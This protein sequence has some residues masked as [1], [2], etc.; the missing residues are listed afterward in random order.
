[1]RSF[2]CCARIAVSASNSSF[3]RSS[4]DSDH[5]SIS[6]AVS[7]V[8]VTGFTDASRTSLIFVSADALATST[9]SA[10]IRS[11]SAFVRTL[12]AAK[13]H[14]PS[15]IARTLKPSVS[16]RSTISSAPFFTC[17]S[18]TCLRTKRTS[19]YVAPRERAV[20]SA[21][22]ARSRSD[23]NAGTVIDR[24][25]PPLRSRRCARSL[26]EPPLVVDVLHQ[27]RAVELD[28]AFGEQRAVAEVA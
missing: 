23:E 28:R 27:E 1:M 12:D 20:S 5:G 11:A 19:L 18:S 7:Y 10:A 8:A 21:R 9:A 26:A 4:N 3:N 25:I 24:F 13:P 6:T 16:V 22:R 2:G 17:A 15:V 14:E